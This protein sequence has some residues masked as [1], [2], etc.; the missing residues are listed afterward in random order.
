LIQNFLSNYGMRCSGEIDVTRARWSEAPSTLV[1]VILS[2][3]RNLAP[4]ARAARI[5]RSRREVEEMREDLIQRLEQVPGS[6]RKTRKLLRMI[7]RLH[8]FSGYREY[9]KYLMMRHYW[10]L[11]QAMLTEASKLA[12]DGVIQRPDDVYY[13]SFEEFREAIRTGHVDADLVARWRDAVDSG[14]DS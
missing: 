14:I 3:I 5:E 6:R 11:K 8:N 13:L 10:I 9:P 2:T 12:E 4:N 1:P 7:D